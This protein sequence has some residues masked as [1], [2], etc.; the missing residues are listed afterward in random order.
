MHHYLTIHAPIP[1]TLPIQTCISVADHS[2]VSKIR[3]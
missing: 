1:Q 3:S 2:P